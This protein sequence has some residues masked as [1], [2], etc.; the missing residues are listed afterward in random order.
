MRSDLRII[1][2][3][4]KRG[5]FGIERR[6]N[7]YDIQRQQ[8]PGCSG[9]AGGNPPFPAADELRGRHADLF[10]E[11][12]AEIEL[13]TVADLLG[14]LPQQIIRLV[15]ILFGP[16]DSQISQII[17]RALTVG[18]FEQAAEVFGCQSG[19]SGQLFD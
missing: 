6:R 13:I 9:R 12:A 17:H 11:F 16:A 7:G 10:F 3:V 14:Y 2:I 18:F 1:F 5:P 15:Q 4:I 8:L 19:H